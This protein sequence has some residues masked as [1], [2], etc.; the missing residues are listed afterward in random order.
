MIQLAW[1]RFVAPHVLLL[2]SL[3]AR[4]ARVTRHAHVLPGRDT[5]PVETEPLSRD[6]LVLVMAQVR[7]GAAHALT[8]V[9]A[10]ASP[11]GD[12]RW[13]LAQEVTVAASS[14]VGALDKLL[15]RV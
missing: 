11:L 5:I 4:V 6:K 12:T 8:A 14:S 15:G 9:K 10:R 7:V 13:M 2:A 3:G 1:E